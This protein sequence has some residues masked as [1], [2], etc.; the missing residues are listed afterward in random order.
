[1]I[2]L[3]SPAKRMEEKVHYPHLEFTQ[4]RL[5]PEAAKL[6]EPLRALRP[7]QLAALMSVSGELA[8]ETHARFAAW[9]P[10]FHPANAIQAV[11]L[12]R[13]EVYRGL[14]ATSLGAEELAFA[15]RHLRILSGLY[16][17]LRPLDLVQPYRLMMGTRFAPSANA[18]NLYAFWGDR[19]AKTLLSDLTTTEPVMNLASAEYADSVLPFLGGRKVYQCDFME[20]KGATLRAV[21]TYTKLARGMMARFIIRHRIDKPE[22][23]K[24]FAENGYRYAPKSSDAFTLVFVRG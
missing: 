4:P 11:L 17:L 9:S 13:G 21:Q 10:P 14:E 8:A 2:T 15:Q 3:I 12:F 22:G 5:L 24:E 23:L 1:M 19:I 16:G 7:E 6:V 18:K 20:K